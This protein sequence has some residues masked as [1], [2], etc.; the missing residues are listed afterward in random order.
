[1]AKSL[2]SGRGTAK[3]RTV[4]V[5]STRLASFRLVSS[6]FVSF[7]LVETTISNQRLSQDPGWKGVTSCERL[8]VKI[9]PYSNSYAN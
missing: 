3:V 6:R 8:D 1:M 9:V 4:V 7:R 5:L 2:P